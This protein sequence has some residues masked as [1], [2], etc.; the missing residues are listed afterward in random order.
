LFYGQPD[1]AGL[2][3][4]RANIAMHWKFSLLRYEAASERCRY[5]YPQPISKFA[6]L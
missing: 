1:L 3:E 6:E 5:M 2:R 4:A